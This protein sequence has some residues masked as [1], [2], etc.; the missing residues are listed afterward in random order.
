PS[1]AQWEYAARAGTETKYW[2]GNTASHEYANYGADQCCGGLKKGKDDWI[3]TSPVGSFEP[4][5]FGLYDLVGNVW[6][7]IADPY[8]KNYEDAPKDGS[9]WKEGEEGDSRILRGGSWRNLPLHCRIA[10]RHKTDSDD[11]HIG[12]RCYRSIIEAETNVH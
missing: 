10:N 12:F 4:N 7:W 1:E 3:E 9:I 2:W 6:E 5:P 8:H 11:K